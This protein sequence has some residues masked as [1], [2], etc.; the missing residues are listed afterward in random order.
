[1]TDILHDRMEITDVVIRYATAIDTRDWA[2]FRTCW[3]D[4]VHTDYGTA[5]T[6]FDDADSFCAFQ[7]QVHS[8]MGVTLHNFSNITI[9]LAGDTATTRSHIHAVI[10]GM[11]GDPN[12]WTEVLGYYDDEFV[13]LPQGWRIRRRKYNPVR[14]LTSGS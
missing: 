4:D 8:K 2:L 10:M 5:R 11:G 9:Q 12:A 6:I 1:M 14:K 7:E 3:A 13:R